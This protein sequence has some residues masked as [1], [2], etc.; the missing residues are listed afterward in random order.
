VCCW[1]L[2]VFI[3]TGAAFNKHLIH[4]YAYNG[5]N[6]LRQ[7]LEVIQSLVAACLAIEP[8]SV[9]IALTCLC[10]HRLMPMLVVLMIWLLLIQTNNFVWSPV[11]MTS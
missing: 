3:V 8:K 7:H 2:N 11:E 1:Y 4:L 9:T 10:H 6:D 5:P